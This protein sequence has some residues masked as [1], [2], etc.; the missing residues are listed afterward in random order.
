MFSHYRTLGFFLKKENRGEA[1]QL[2][3]IFTKDF[4]KLKVLGRAI[5]KVK[6]K[7]RAGAE[8]FLLSEIEFIQGKT[9]KTLTD[10]ILIDKYN[11]I[12]KSVEKMDCAYQIMD[13][14]DSLMIA[15]EQDENI[16]K[17]LNE[18]FQKLDNQKTGS[19]PPWSRFQRDYSGKNSLRT[20]YYFFLWNF[21]S[22]L[23]Y[24]VELYSCVICQKKLRPEVFWFLPNQG[25]IVCSKCFKSIKKEEN[26]EVK[27]IN[28]STAKV[29]RIIIDGNWNILKRLKTKEEDKRNLKEISYL[30]LSF[31]KKEF[32]KRGI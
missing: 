4:G 29:L 18:T 23:G 24:E 30:Y 3:T 16:W 32:S 13:A 5:R 12:R 31:L 28:I 21:F 22:V 1:D 17:L 6:S 20:I 27:K 19:L 15:R 11:G 8:L 10:T 25:G 9:Y 14:V 26:E 2:L 7:L